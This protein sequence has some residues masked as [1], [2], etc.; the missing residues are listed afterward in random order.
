VKP[1][2][3]ARNI[4]KSFRQADGSF[5]KVIEDVSLELHSQEIVCLLG[6]SGSGKSSLLQILAGLHPLDTGSIKLNSSLKCNTVDILGKGLKRGKPVK[7][8]AGCK[9]LV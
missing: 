7:V 4:S 6:P 9:I 3:S 2:L 5:L 1:V 8:F